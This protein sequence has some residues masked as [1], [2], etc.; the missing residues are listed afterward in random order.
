MIA[1]GVCALVLV[2]MALASI[3]LMVGPTLYDRALA[4]HA[5]ALLG[6]IGLAALAV[7]AKAA[8][9]I[10]AAIALVLADV[11]LAVAVLKFFRFRSLQPPMAP[12]ANEDRA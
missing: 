10:D 7:A 3:R 9:W 5:L 4:A 2:A 1:L 11:V 6:A 8:V 12:A